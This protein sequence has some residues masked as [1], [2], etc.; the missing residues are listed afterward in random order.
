MK[1]RNC[2]IRR[3]HLHQDS[4]VVFDIH[5]LYRM[6]YQHPANFCLYRHFRIKD[7]RLYCGDQRPGKPM[8]VI[9]QKAQEW[10]RGI[11]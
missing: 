4:V 1:N 9:G 8:P 11:K 6:N 2:L 10:F 3:R 7:H 5:S